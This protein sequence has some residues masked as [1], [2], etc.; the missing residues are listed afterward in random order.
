MEGRTFERK[1]T[2]RA[3]KAMKKRIAKGKRIALKIEPGSCKLGTD[4]ISKISDLHI[5][6]AA[7]TG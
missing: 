5:I 6:N 1:I 2:K 3:L 7:P 4:E